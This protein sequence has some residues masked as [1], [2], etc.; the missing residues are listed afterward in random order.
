MNLSRALAT[1]GFM[2]EVELEY[3]AHIATTATAI[4]EIGSWQGRST[5]AMADNTEGRIWCVDTWADDAFGSAPAEQT[6]KPGW[7]MDAFAKNHSDTIASGKVTR[8]RATSALGAE[9]MR[10]RTFDLIFIDAGHSYEDVKSDILAWRPL[11]REGGTLCGH[12]LYPDGPY[13]PGVK[14]AVAELIGDYSLNGTIWT[15]QC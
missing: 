1:P 5:R 15:A 11:L 10:E 3:L 12:D 9:I 8:V 13:H 4:A 2:H 7:L 6:S 14:Q